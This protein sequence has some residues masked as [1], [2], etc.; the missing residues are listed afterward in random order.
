M[1][2]TAQHKDSDYLNGKNNKFD[3]HQTWTVGDI[4]VHLVN[5]LRSVCYVITNFNG[6]VLKLENR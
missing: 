5:P 4:D 3:H 2:G 6:C 1:A